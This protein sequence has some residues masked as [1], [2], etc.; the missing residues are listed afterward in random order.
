MK[1]GISRKGMRERIEGLQSSSPVQLSLVLALPGAAREEAFF[2]ARFDADRMHG[3][4]FVLSE[5]IRQFVLE[6]GGVMP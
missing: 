6:S 4:W 2:H 3:E 5:S 1:I